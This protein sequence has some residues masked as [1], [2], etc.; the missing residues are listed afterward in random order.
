M[1]KRKRSSEQKAKER[2]KMRKGDVLTCTETCR[3]TKETCVTKLEKDERDR[4]NNF[5]HS[6]GQKIN[7]TS[8][9]Y[10]SNESINIPVKSKSDKVKVTHEQLSGKDLNTTSDENNNYPF[11]LERK[12]TFQVASIKW[13]RQTKA[14]Q[15]N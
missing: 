11:T 5:L 15:L 9:L 10:T 3:E 6:K 13:K 14:H 12:N 4:S 8:E 2:R 7:K 1:A